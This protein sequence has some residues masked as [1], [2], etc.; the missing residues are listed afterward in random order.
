ME[1][2]RGCLQ[3]GPAADLNL[4]ISAEYLNKVIFSCDHAGLV[5][6][7]YTGA[8]SEP[9]CPIRLDQ[10]SAHMLDPQKKDCANEFHL[11]G[12]ISFSP[13]LTCAP[14]LSLPSL[15]FCFLLIEGFDFGSRPIAGRA[16]PWCRDELTVQLPYWDLNKQLHEPELV[17]AYIHASNAWQLQG[18]RCP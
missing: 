4:G 10:S 11:G 16:P 9:L 3:R 5:Q 17:A 13:P 14:C 12:K 7:A 6:V 18:L 8:R 1:G 2:G 15:F